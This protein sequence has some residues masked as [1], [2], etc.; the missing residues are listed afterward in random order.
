MSKLK[1]A[2][3]SWKECLLYG[4]IALILGG[5]IGVIDA[6]FGKGLI[7]ISRFRAAH[8]GWLLPFL[9]PAGLMIVWVYTRF[10][11]GA[12][13]GMGL[14]FAVG[15]GEED[16]IPLRLVPFVFVSTWLTHLCGGSAGREGVAVQ[17][18]ATVSH[19]AARLLAPE[20]GRIFLIAGMAA[21][22][23]GLFCTPIA[24]TLFAL[25]VLCAGKIYYRALFPS[26]VAAFAASTVS[27]LLG[28]SKFAVAVDLGFDPDAAFF[29]K[30]LVLGLIFG[31]V[32]R[33]FSDLLDYMKKFFARRIPNPYIR[34]AAVGL[35]LTALLLFLRGGRYCGLGTNLIEGS[36]SGEPIYAYDW[37]LKL[38]LTILTLSAGYQGGEVTPL[39]SIGTSLG[40]ALAG[41][42]RL[43][44]TLVSALGY[45]AVFGSATNTFFAPILIG[46]EVFGF[47][48]LP[49]F[50]I[51][52]TASYCFGS[53][54]SIY[55][56]QKIL[57]DDAVGGEE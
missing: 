17:I 5:V 55:S 40:A 26:F 20:A 49:L 19:W 53:H 42:F 6:V 9:A 30:L 31:L 52:C 7:A 46:A 28:L 50:F 39:F 22:F 27:S 23:S 44:V 45:A 48:N 4:F 1:R 47:E 21:G 3:H 8:T 10:G 37:I 15:H 16:K 29:V 2:A 51:V 56:A 35:C 11:N 24:A 54:R 57:A 25:E 12:G 34:V 38:L 33:L 43:P 18:G 41:I 36:F 13:R 14:V 32:G